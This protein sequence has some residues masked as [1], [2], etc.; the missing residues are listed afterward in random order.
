MSLTAADAILKNSGA[1]RLTNS[2]A[3]SYLK[4]SGDVVPIPSMSPYCPG[5][6]DGIKR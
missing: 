4:L 3:E 5:L 6:G 2:K 1:F